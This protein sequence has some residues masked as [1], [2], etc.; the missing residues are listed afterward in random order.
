MKGL[1]VMLPVLALVFVSCALLSRERPAV[2]VSEETGRKPIL[3]NDRPGIATP[4]VGPKTVSI[5]SREE[6]N[7]V[8]GYFYDH[9]TT[10]RIQTAEVRPRT[11]KAGQHVIVM[12]TYAVLTHS[13]KPVKITETLETRFKDKIW[14]SSRIET[15]RKGGTYRSSVP[16]YLPP[17]SEKGNYRVSC[18]V[19]TPYSRDLREAVFFVYDDEVETSIRK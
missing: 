5:R 12:L 4:R 15:E 17:H 2:P 1:L 10:A 14:E 19:Q 3:P 8:F 7:K 18:T 11:A 16:L 6:T 9:G 13:D